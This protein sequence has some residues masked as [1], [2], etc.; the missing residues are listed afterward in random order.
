MVLP[1]Q[2]FTIAMGIVY[3]I[4]KYPNIPQRH[5][6]TSVGEHSYKKCTPNVGCIFLK[7][8]S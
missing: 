8:G 7:F 5:R 4:I 2:F 6:L 3:S 1:L